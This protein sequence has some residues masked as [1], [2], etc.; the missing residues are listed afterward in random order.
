MSSCGTSTPTTPSKEAL[1]VIRVNGV[2]IEE[3]DLANE[4]QYHANSNFD[5][6]VQQAGQTLVIRQ[7]L[8]EQA[9]KHGF[10]V[11]GD[12]EEAGVQQ[13]LETQVSYDD[14]KEEDCKR[15]FDNNREK[16]TTMPL[17]EVDH[18][19]LAAAKDDIDGRDDAKTDALDIISRL[20]KDPSLF[21]EL[22]KHHSA[23]PSKDT[24]GSLG[25]ISNGQ[26][27]PEFEKQLM[28]LPQGL[29]PKPI[30]SR[31]GFHVVNIA[32][33]IDG[34]PLEYEMVY[35]KVRGYLVH[36]ASHLAIQAYIHGLVE[37]A[38]VEGVEVKFADEN[39]Y[40]Q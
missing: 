38:D 27:V 19:L 18:I 39:I 20:Q 6:V 21:A 16:F 11:T 13:L 3:T 33:K 8:I 28:L 1:P 37:M 29:A 5:L 22:A 4:L 17:M 31:Y 36:R 10:D 30:E 15:Y 2:T 9:Q 7:L 26:T 14:P 40:V 35:D 32:R 24:G 34:K 12:N 25:Q 23:C